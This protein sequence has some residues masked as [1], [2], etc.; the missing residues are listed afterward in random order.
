LDNLTLQEQGWL[1]TAVTASNAQLDW[2]DVVD[3]YTAASVQG[4]DYFGDENANSLSGLDGDDTFYA[5]GGDD[6]L[7]GA[8]GDDLFFGAGGSDQIHGENG[9]DTL[10]GGDG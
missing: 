1:S 10:H 4:F 8:G 3:A 9:N 6:E 2:N 7:H 5:Y